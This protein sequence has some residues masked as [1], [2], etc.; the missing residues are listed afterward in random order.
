[1]TNF[2]ANTADNADFVQISAAASREIR[3]GTV[4]RFVKRLFDVIF[5]AL[6]LVILAIP[7]AVISLAVALD[8]RG[9]VIFR[10]KRVGKDGRE[11][12]ILKFRTMHDDTP[13][14]IPT[15]DL[16]RPHAYITKTG[17]FLRVS[18]LDELPQLINI[19]R[20]DMSLVGPRPLIINET[21]IH[22]M[23]SEQGVYSVRPGVTGWAQVNGRDNL[24][25]EEKVKFDSYYVNNCSLLFDLSIL[26]RTVWVVIKREGF[27]EG[28]QKYS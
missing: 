8:S 12:F 7:F 13:A 23:R 5:A 20:G 2:E 4:Y 24:S 28:K 1:M 9:A 18:S 19:L 25:V 16:E 26:F 11:F 14:Y 27:S 6:S 17:S 22:T 21:A 15:G 3:G 10:Q